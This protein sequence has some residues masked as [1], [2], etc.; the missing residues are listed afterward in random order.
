MNRYNQDFEIKIFNIIQELINNI[1]KHSK[2]NHAKIALKE[3]K[4]QLTILIRDDGVGFTPSS[5][6]I[7][8]GI[9]LNQIDAR[10]HVLN[11]KFIISSELNK[12]TEAIITVPIQ[13][14]KKEFKLTSVS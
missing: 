7:K 4:N 8:D 6:S 13:Q 10:I 12:G 9:G 14:Q 5:S 11:G 1:I 2:A 3:E